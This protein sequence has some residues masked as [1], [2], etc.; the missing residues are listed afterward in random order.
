M[1]CFDKGDRDKEI[2]VIQF[3]YVDKEGNKR[4]VL[5]RKKVSVYPKLKQHPI[6]ELNDVYKYRLIKIE[7]L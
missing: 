4:G 2:I 6:Y 3:V 1:L 7:R 5:I